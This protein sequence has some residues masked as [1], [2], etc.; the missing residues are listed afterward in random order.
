MLAIGG[1]EPAPVANAV[2][3]FVTLWISVDGGST[4][5]I[6]DETTR[7]PTESGRGAWAFTRFGDSAVLVGNDD[8]PSGK[9]PE[10]GWMTWAR[11]PAVW[12]TSLPAQ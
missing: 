5:Q 7:L 10:Y 1:Y 3:S 11:T 12:I 4:W 9:H 6:T 2:P 8:I